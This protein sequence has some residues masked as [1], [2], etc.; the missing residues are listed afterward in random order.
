MKGSDKV[1]AFGVGQAG[2]TEWTKHAK[3]EQREVFEIIR[4]HDITWLYVPMGQL[5][6]L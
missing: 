3:V 1:P 4:N 2:L 6:F 5:L